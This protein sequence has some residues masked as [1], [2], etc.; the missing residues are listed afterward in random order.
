MKIALPA[1]DNML[2]PSSSSI[3][4]S[5]PHATQEKVEQLR[6]ALLRPNTEPLD[7]EQL[8]SLRVRLSTDADSDPAL[9]ILGPLINLRMSP[10]S[11]TLLQALERL[12]STHD[13]A[14]I[15]ELL[16]GGLNIPSTDLRQLADAAGIDL[17][18]Y[19][20]LTCSEGKLIT[21]LD[22]S[23]DED[24]AELVGMESDN[25]VYCR[26]ASTSPTALACLVNH[27]R[28][29]LRCLHFEGFAETLLE[30]SLPFLRY[31]NLCRID[32]EK[33][34]AWLFKTNPSKLQQLL[35]DSDKIEELPAELPQLQWL[36]CDYCTALQALPAKL[37]QLQRIECRYCTSLQALPAELP[38][39]LELDCS[40]CT[41][42]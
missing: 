8:E 30:E 16:A 2:S 6:A 20:L 28:I 21:V 36:K 15:N 37:P 5:E 33:Q 35:I 38:Q 1:N 31:C 12:K 13:P 14:S 18:S 9:R 22:K 40:N 29:S 39:L 19:Q 10:D 25:I 42:L 23:S 3:K 41:A 11:E 27:F 24:P 26:R 4:N 32:S 17:S 7:Y 34:A